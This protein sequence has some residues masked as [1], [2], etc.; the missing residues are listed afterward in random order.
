[1]TDKQ[2][3]EAMEWVEKEIED[4]EACVKS[5]VGEFDY[6]PTKDEEEQCAFL[7]ESLGYLKTILSA[8]E[9]K[10][11]TE[12]QIETMWQSTCDCFT[13]YH[14]SYRHLFV[15]ALLEWFKELGITVKEE[16]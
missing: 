6:Y 14:E 3:K 13:Y 7:E 15:K 10:V 5:L 16:K 9:P 4:R 2:R 11:V 8:L 1:M 12:G